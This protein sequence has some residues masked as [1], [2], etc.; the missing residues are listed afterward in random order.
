[1]AEK[2]EAPLDD[3][4]MAMDVVDTLR[5]DESVVMKELGAQ[6]RDAG[7]I[8]RLREIYASQGI[9]VP[10]HILQSGV[11]GLKEDRFVY[12]PPASGFQRMLALVY[13]SRLRWSKWAA[14]VLLVVVIAVAA[15]QF[16]IIAP[17]ERAAAALKIELAEQLPARLATLGERIAALAQDPDVKSD[18]ARIQ[19]DGLIAAKD[20]DADAA[21]KSVTDLTQ[22]A[23][24]LSAVF[25][26]RIVSRPG[27]PT[28]VTRIPDVNRKVNNYYLV[29]EALDPDGKAISRKVLSEE[30][31]K[32]KDVTIWAQR[33]SKGLFDQVRNDKKDDGIVQ[34]A[35]IGTKE[36]GQRDVDWTTGVQ[37]GAI[38]KW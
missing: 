19:A 21:R 4:M 35:L 15:W 6:D 34:K 10:D 3:L 22:L 17:R 12:A 2:A 20:G 38:T 23:S 36:R 18:A 31:S 8:D 26:V 25:T 32:S 24:D 16:L 29:V 11:E 1:M 33:V 30:D 27:T 14:G 28:G 9:E 37:D 5:H 7:M 13:V